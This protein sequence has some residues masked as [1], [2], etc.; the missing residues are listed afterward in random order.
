[1]SRY[2]INHGY[3][4]PTR[5]DTVRDLMAA[6]KKK[7]DRTGPEHLMRTGMPA[8][9]MKQIL[10]AGLPVDDPSDIGCCA[11]TIFAF[12]FQCRAVSV[13]HR[14]VD[15]I[16]VTTDLIDVK[17]SH[18]NGKSRRPLLL[19]YPSQP[20]DSGTSPQYLLFRWQSVRPQS[21]GYFNLRTAQ[22]L[23]T[24]DLAVTVARVLSIVNAS[25]PKGYYFGS[26]SPRI[27]GLNELVNLGFPKV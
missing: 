2:H 17:L 14:G 26:H 7:A 22:P 3:A 16:A 13:A 21:D 20:W 6:F 23:G 9:L 27:G 15:D 25:A 5:T 4:S 11:I 24:A 19:P 10:E 1:M 8:G 12:I 18:R